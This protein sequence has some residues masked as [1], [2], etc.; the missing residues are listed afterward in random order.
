MTAPAPYGFRPATPAD[1]DLLNGWTANPHVARWWDRDH[2]F[3]A[4]DLARPD[5]AA[6]IVTLEGRALAY[7]QD[8]ALHGDEPHPYDHLPKGTRGI[9]QFI[10]D[11]GMTGHGHGP[12]FI[13]QHVETLF[14]AGAPAIVTDPHPDNARAI[15]AYRKAG[16]EIDGPA[17][18]TPWG[19]A[20]PMVVWRQSRAALS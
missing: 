7:L 2:L 18:D 5:V 6:W 3:D 16:F 9:D 11:A 4:D 19:R 12:R 8:Y 20:Q 17:M 1:L 13:R 15:A 14:A 10:G